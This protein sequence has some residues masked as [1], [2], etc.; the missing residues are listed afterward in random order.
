[1]I[2]VYLGNN[3]AC[4]STLASMTSSADFE[5]YYRAGLDV[6]AGAVETKSAIIHISAIPA[7]YWLWEALRNDEWCLFAWQFVPCEN[8]LADPVNDCGA[9]ESHLNPDVIHADDG[10]NCQRRKQ[11][12]AMIRD[13]YN[14]ILKNVLQE[15]IQDGRLPN[16]YY[17]NVFGIQFQAEHINTGDCFHPSVKGQ[18][19]LAQNQWDKSPWADPAPVCSE[20]QDIPSFSPWLYLLL[21]N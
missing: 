12:H 9:G 17:N 2:T 1:M 18:A 13:T 5:Y 19:F 14:P 15:Y 8:L 10:P 20:Q 11:L 3:D 6:L 16:A 21:S 7:I 4:S